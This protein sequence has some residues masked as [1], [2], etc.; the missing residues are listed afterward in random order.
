MSTIALYNALIKAG[1]PRNDAEKAVNDLISTDDAATKTDIAK[2][3][4]DIAKLGFSL[5]IAMAV[6]TGVAVGAVA[7]LIK[8]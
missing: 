7:L 6:Y 5:L 1:V 2:L 8:P 4:R 3:E